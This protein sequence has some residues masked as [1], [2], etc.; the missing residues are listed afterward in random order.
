MAQH[1]WAN[2]G[3]TA[4]HNRNDTIGATVNDAGGGGKKLS[5]CFFKTMAT[6]MI[7]I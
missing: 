1:Q 3:C 4:V 5:Y 6:E 7:I 2:E